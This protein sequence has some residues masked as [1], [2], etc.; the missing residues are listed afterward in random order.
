MNVLTRPLALSYKDAKKILFS[1]SQG[2]KFIVMLIGME[3]MNVFLP[4]QFETKE[5]NWFSLEFSSGQRLLMSKENWLKTHL[6]FPSEEKGVH[7]KIRVGIYFCGIKNPRIRK[8][9]L[10][11]LLLKRLFSDRLL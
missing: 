6:Q 3:A 7:R 8:V 10:K 5:N 11:F 4:W 2:Q 1:E 9:N